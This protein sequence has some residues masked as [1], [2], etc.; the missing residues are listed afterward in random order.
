MSIPRVSTLLA[1][2]AAAVAGWILRPLPLKERAEAVITASMTDRPDAEVR[3]AYARLPLAEL[4][5]QRL[6]ASDLRTLSLVFEAVYLATERTADDASTEAL[7]AIQAEARS[8]G[9]IGFNGAMPAALFDRAL[10]RRDF[11]LA[12]RLAADSGE[13][14][15]K[16]PRVVLPANPGSRPAVL[17]VSG[18]GRTLAWAAVDLGPGPKLVALVTPGCH[19]SQQAMAALGAD[20]ALRRAAAGGLFVDSNLAQASALSAANRGNWFRYDLLYKSEGWPKFDFHGTPRFYFLKDGAVVAQIE[21][22]RSK[23]FLDDYR[24]GLTA[25][26]L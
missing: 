20:P 17:R 2:G 25:I 26:G 21:G 6:K 24:R 13:L 15:V 19:F 5:P 9:F 16:L 23:E 18:D 3:S 11:A 22:Y 1:V 10:S 12:G 7:S 14:A 4:T 8:R